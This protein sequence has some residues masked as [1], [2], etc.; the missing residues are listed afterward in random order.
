[1]GP[2]HAKWFHWILS[3]FICPIEQGLTSIQE[4]H[5]RGTSELH[6]HFVLVKA[7]VCLLALLP[8]W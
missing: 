2:L 7:L 6:P 4:I 3:E 5:L 1:M 8:L